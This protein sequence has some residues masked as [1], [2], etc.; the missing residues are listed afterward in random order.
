MARISV[1]ENITLDGVAQGPGTAEEDTRGG[2]TA[3]GWAGRFVDAVAMEAS[4]AG[5]ADTTGIL[6]GRRTWADFERAWG[7]G[8]G[9]PFSAFLDRIP[10]YVCSRTLH[11]PLSWQNSVLLE[12]EAVDTV[13]RLKAEAT[14]AI[15]V[16]GS[17]D[18]VRSLAR[19]D[20]VDEYVLQIHPIVLAQ[21]RRLFDGWVPAEFAL[22]RT[23]TT[24][25]GVIMATY[26]RAA[27]G[28]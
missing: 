28:V 24:G 1:V 26:Q 25:T 11:A 2:F 27:L 17:I 21:G 13:T 19:A 10:K 18:L 3:G 23:V 7:G 12:G 15:T 20:L 5:M 6:F 14:G 16:L 8:S 9:N 4:Q 22:A